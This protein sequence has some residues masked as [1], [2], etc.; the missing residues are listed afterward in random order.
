MG[1]D[2]GVGLSAELVAFF[3]E[4]FLQAH[5]VLND[6]VVNDDDLAGAVAMGMRVFFGGTSVGGPASVSD[7]VGAVE[8]L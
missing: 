4:L 8:R 1:D 7:A 5:V 3:D 2:F 6:A